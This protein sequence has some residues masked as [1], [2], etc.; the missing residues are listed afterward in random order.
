[1]GIEQDA[2]RLV[3]RHNAFLA[4]T[5]EAVFLRVVKREFRIP[6]DKFTYSDLLAALDNLAEPR[7]EE[8]ARNVISDSLLAFLVKSGAVLYAELPE[9]SETNRYL[10]RHYSDPKTVAEAI[11][12]SA[13]RGLG[14]ALDLEYFEKTRDFYGF[15]ETAEPGMSENG[16]LCTSTY[17]E[18]RDLI[19]QT[20]Y[21]VYAILAP[22]WYREGDLA[23]YLCDS[24]QAALDC[25]TVIP[26]DLAFDAFERDRLKQRALLNYAFLLLMDHLSAGPRLNNVFVLTRH[27]D[28]ENINMIY[29]PLDQPIFEPLDREEGTLPGRMEALNQMMAASKKATRYKIDVTFDFLEAGNLLVSLTTPDRYVSVESRAETLGDSLYKG[30][31]ELFNHYFTEQGIQGKLLVGKEDHQAFFQREDSS[32]YAA[33]KIPEFRSCGMTWVVPKGA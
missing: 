4:E 16:L 17:A 5:E 1:M 11:R 30:L 12:H 33:L 2:R 8:E 3:Y 23:V 28:V 19:E 6:K 10:I 21:G 24:R 13:V 25:L 18:L 15:S 7:T 27:L 20:S 32:C 22:F 9:E 14:S 31:C 26:Q 29:Q